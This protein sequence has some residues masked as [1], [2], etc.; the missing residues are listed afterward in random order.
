MIDVNFRPHMLAFENAIIL[1][2]LSRDRNASNFAGNYMYM[3]TESNGR[4]AFKHSITRCYIFVTNETPWFVDKLKCV[5]GDETGDS[6][7]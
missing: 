6:A 7:L 4:D 2:S 1:G 3:Y 5:P